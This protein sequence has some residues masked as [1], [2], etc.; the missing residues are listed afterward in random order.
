MAVSTPNIYTMCHDLF[1]K[2]I[3]CLFI[4]ISTLAHCQVSEKYCDSL[5]E[6]GV[7]SAKNDGN[8]VNA[9]EHLTKAQ[10]IAQKNGWNKQLFSCAIN[11]GNCYSAMLDYGESLKYYL[12][13]YNIAVKNNYKSREIA[14]LNNVAGLYTME[15]ELDKAEEYLKRAYTISKQEQDSAHT[16]I[17]SLNLGKLM[18][19]MKKHKQSEAYFDEA[20]GYTKNN[21]N[22]YVSISAGI[23]EN[24]FERGNVKRAKDLALSLLS[25]IPNKD[26]TYET[27]SLYLVISRYYLQ[28]DNF[29]EAYRYA[30]LVL[31]NKNT[32]LNIKRTVYENF[33]EIYEKSHSYVE[34]LRYRDSVS[35]I[36]D[37]L[38]DIN[39]GRQYESNRVK[40]EVQDYKN[41]IAINTATIAKDRKIFYAVL[42]CITAVLIL[43]IFIF[44]Y[45]SVKHK[46]KKLIAENNQQL[47]ALKLAATQGEALLQEKQFKEKQYEILLEQEQLKNEIENKNRKL[48]SKALYTSGKYQM[49]KDIIG[50]L[51]D[52]P[53]VAEIPAVKKHIRY[54]RNSLNIDNEW[55][56]FLTHF[57]EVNQG[58]LT[59]LKTAHPEL[60]ANDIRF[61]CYVYMN[62]N[63]KEIADM[64][65][66]SLDACRKRKERVSQKLGLKDSSLLFSYLYGI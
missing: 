6:K 56:G 22:L 35:V 30:S 26:E 19:Q 33:S 59:R 28:E 48:S 52:Q 21:F 20:L 55:A 8:Y 39:N 15:E 13:A 57:E 65:N 24:E 32:D 63:A 16:G 47:L 51:S 41:Q 10:S 2:I 45:I 1:K 66:I 37:K 7:K 46:Q 23:A 34:A 50:M 58:F 27:I 44:R 31:T 43:I 12:E 61:I 3:I 25:K 14:A 49:I 18:I 17:Y 36:K 54:L 9:L 5:I 62:L 53:E 60:T 64:L 29:D 11:I 4:F 42:G 38:N 40:F